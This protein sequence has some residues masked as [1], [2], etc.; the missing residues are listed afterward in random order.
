MTTNPRELLIARKC[1]EVIF[2][3]GYFKG[4]LF[5]TNWYWRCFLGVTRFLEEKW[6]VTALKADFA[7]GGITASMVDLHEK[8]LIKKILDVQSFDAIAAESLARTPN[9]IEVSATNMR[10]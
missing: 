2:A 6:Y 10:T 5:L 8:G 7:L 4:R 3:S 1:A 9:H